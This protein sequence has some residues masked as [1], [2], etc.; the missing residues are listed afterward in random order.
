MISFLTR[1]VYENVC[2]RASSC[3]FYCAQFLSAKRSCQIWRI[4]LDDLKMI[5][6]PPD[7]AAPAVVL[8]DYGQ[9]H[10]KY[11]QEHGFSLVFERLRRIKILKTEGLDMANVKIRLYH[12]NNNEEKVVNLKGITVNLENGKPVE[13]KLKN[14]MVF[15]EPFDKYNNLV[16]FSMPNVKVGSILEMTYTINS[17]FF[18]NFNDW[19]FQTSVPTVWSE[20]RARIPEYFNYDKYAQGYVPFEIQESTRAPGQIILRSKERSE[21]R[22]TQTQF[23]ENKIDYV[24]N[25]FRWAAKDVPAFKDEP[26]L[27]TRNDYISRIN[28]ELAYTKFPNQPIENYM[29][30]W[31]EINK[32]YYENA[33]FGGEVR[34]NGFL[35]KIVDEVTAGMTKPEDKITAIVKYVKGNVEWDGHSTDHSSSQ[36]KKVLELKKGN[37]AEINILIAS[38]IE[39]TGLMVF[40]VLSSTRDHG[41]IRQ[42]YPQSTQFNYVLCLVR[43]D[44]RDIILDA[45]EPLLPV[46][47]IP[48]RC[49]NGMGM[50]VAK[51]GPFWV[52][53]INPTKTRVVAV[54]KFNLNEAGNLVG[55]LNVERTGYA[56]L[57]Q[58]KHFLQK[59]E[60]EYLKEFIDTRQWSVS[61]TIIENVKEFWEP[62]KENYNVEIPANATVSGDIIYINPFVLLQ[63]TSNPFKSEIRNYPVD[64]GFSN[65]EVYS[66]TLQIPDGYLVEELPKAKVIMLPQGTSKYSYNILQMGNTITLTSNFSINK[67]L[68][69]QTEYSMIREFY[70]QVVAK[71][72]E[73]IVLKKK[74]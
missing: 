71:Q 28:F 30:S 65:D 24:E 47:I 62:F 1:P 12:R 45:T 34:G 22:V 74:T 69:V 20:Y 18:F 7:T 51:D 72:A 57:R 15:K 49:L 58:R 59:G 41:F 54:G 63:K 43:I 21:G 19:E 2:I 48:E 26:F 61:K 16:N 11:S 68:F 44:G 36:L 25:R 32:T 73:Q 52:D 27:T 64:F 55:E 38:M 23:N 53:L 29:G 60:A 56:G 50:A 67:S 31:Q 35:K 39:K 5:S 9:S 42:S 4:S 13:T 6:Y 8:V 37:S 3:L 70:N 66:I 10:L 40:P 33:D 17:D 14:D 46:D